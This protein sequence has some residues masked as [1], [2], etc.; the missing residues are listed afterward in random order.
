MTDEET[1]FKVMTAKELLVPTKALRVKIAIHINTI[2]RI[3]C[4]EAARELALAVTNLQL[5]R[6]WLQQLVNTFDPLSE[7]LE[8]RDPSSSIL[9]VDTD[10]SEEYLPMDELN[11]IETIKTLLSK[12]AFYQ[13]S[14]L[15]DM[16]DL[17]TKINH[18][19]LGSAL[20]NYN[21]PNNVIKQLREA[22]M[23]LIAV[24]Q[25]VKNNQEKI[26]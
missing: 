7:S 11:N 9:E 26:N 25:V 19:E 15:S 16:H 8:S 2:K 20:R 17:D 4:A 1:K 14:L 21:G 3:K 22:D 18:S 6:M 10:T 23:W 24:L 5:S 13:D 12:T